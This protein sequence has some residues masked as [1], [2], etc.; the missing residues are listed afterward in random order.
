MTT[1]ANT[2]TINSNTFTTKTTMATIQVPAELFFQ[3][4]AKLDSIH[5]ILTSGG[6][7]VNMDVDVTKTSKKA[8]KVKKTKDPNAP[9]R[10]NT[11][12]CLFLKAK[13]AELG[14]GYK[15]T[16]S[17]PE[18]M[19][20]WKEGSSSNCIEAKKKAA[21]LREQYEKDMAAYN[22]NSTPSQVVE[23]S[24]E[25]PVEPAPKSILKKRRG[26]P[27]GLKAVKKV[28]VADPMAAV[29]K[30][31]AEAKKEKEEE[32]AKIQAQLAEMKK[33]Q[34][35][36]MKSLANTQSNIETNQSADEN[37]EEED[38]MLEEFEYEGSST[39]YNGMTLGIDK[40]TN[41][42]YTVE[43]GDCVLLGTFNSET[44]EIDEE[45][46]ELEEDDLE[47]EE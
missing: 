10:P 44:K 1:Y 14:I 27:K 11:A 5:S 47:E 13:A 16:M 36:L 42:V 21:E 39:K 6:I 40:K 7:P 25:E 45:F 26:R 23:D 8:K 29:L 41:N 46:D 28:T 17:V 4:M 20:E 15:K 2:N 38:E 31:A 43:D 33:Q 37:V 32:E 22:A 12:H 24:D 30:Q 19:A 35:E 9:K 34:D 3:M 18:V